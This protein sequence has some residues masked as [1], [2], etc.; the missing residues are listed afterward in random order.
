MLRRAALL[1]ATVA[2]GCAAPLAVHRQDLV[3]TSVAANYR[4]FYPA[5]GDPDLAHDAGLLRP[6]FGLPAIAQTGAAIAVELLERGGPS[7]VRAALV[8]PDVDAVAAERC[9]GGAVIDGCQLLAL[10]TVDR[11]AVAPTVERVRMT[12]PA[13]APPGAYDLYLHPPCDAP[14]RTP[15]AVWLRADDPAQ[16]AHVKVVQLSDIHIGKHVDAV[17]EHL[18]QVIDEVNAEAPDLILIT[19]DIV[20]QGTDATLPPRAQ[21]LLV[22]LKAPV[23]IVIGNHDIGFRTFV[24]KQ[25]GAGWENFARAFHPFLEFEL[26]LGGYR[27]IGFDSGPSTLSPRIL[28]RGLSPETIAQLTRALDGAAK[29]G[30]R[31][32]VLFS[33]APS[34]TVL[35]GESSPSQ[36]GLFGHMRDGHNAFE[37][38]L[39]VAATHGQRVL[40]LA[41]HTHW[42]DVFEAQPVENGLGGIG[43]LGF[44]RWPDGAGDGVAATIH[45]KAAMVTT[46]AATHAG[47]WPKASAR[48]Y[49]FTTL[50]LGDGDPEVTFHRHDV[51]PASGVAAKKD[52]TSAAK[53]GDSPRAQI[54]ATAD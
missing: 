7:V 17:E 39:L 10:T 32:V 5:D 52:G 34:R 41:G 43:G 3:L 42:D 40:H 25:Y 45:G 13:T 21:A 44:V 20:N 18:K 2:A 49:G 31:G 11:K 12:A 46:Q 16:L 30:T 38:M 28:T 14:T 26:E 4:A 15:R 23:A 50:L 37:R 8:R 24:G 27:F 9:L 47:P 35:T 53:A 33:H 29:S 54:G 6:R 1:L 19:G 36:A 51:A 22:G 48:G